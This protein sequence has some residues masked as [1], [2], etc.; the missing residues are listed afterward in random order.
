MKKLV[1]LIS[2]NKINKK[3][4]SSLEAVLSYGNVK[5]FQLRL[6]SVSKHGLIKI[7]KKIRKIT[8]KHKVKFIINDDFN[9]V[10]KTKADGCHLG[11]LDGS[12]D[13]AK[14]YLKIKFLVSPVITLRLLP[15]KRLEI[16]RAI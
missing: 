3:F 5:F 6:K 9:L 14:K 10:S 7:A 15:K 4:Y 1:Y 8:I 16:K 13:A 2:P 11:Q 12:F